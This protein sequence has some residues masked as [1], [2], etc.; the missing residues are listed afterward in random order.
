MSGSVGLHFGFVHV[1]GAGGMAWVE[2][3][4]KGWVVYEM[5]GDVQY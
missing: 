3:D 5:G 1:Y 4:G 2:R